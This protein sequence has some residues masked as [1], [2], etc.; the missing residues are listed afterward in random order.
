VG[1]TGASEALWLEAA[2][3]AVAKVTTASFTLQS[4]VSL[5][6]PTS[7]Q[8]FTSGS[9]TTDEYIYFGLAGGSSVLGV[10]AGANHLVSGAVQY[11]AVFGSNGSGQHT[12]I[13][14]G[15]NPAMKYDSYGH[16]YSQGYPAPTAGTGTASTAGNDN[17]FT[18]TAGSSVTSSA[19]AFGGTWSVAPKCTVSGNSTTAWPSIS[20]APST[21]AIT[22]NWSASVSGAVATVHCEG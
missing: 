13:M 8:T 15:G 14:A 19:I 5:N 21:T 11:D 9:N 7:P 12:F 18:L 16:Q 20:G 2:A 17:A 4:G 6:V 10:A 3:S 22:I 1:S